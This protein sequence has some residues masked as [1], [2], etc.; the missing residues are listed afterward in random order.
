M[1][2]EHRDR[3]AA[4][5]PALALKELSKSFGATRAV[6][7]LSLSVDHGEVVALLG[8]NGAGKT[9]TIEMCEGFLTPTT[10]SIEVLG[11]NPTTHPEHVRR[12]IG[13]MLQGGGTYP[14]IKVG[15]LLRL[16]ASYS[17]RPL[18]VDWL[19]HTLG[20]EGIVKTNYRRL[21][22]GQ[23]QR[24][25]LACALIGRPELVFLDEPTAGMDAQSRLQVWEIIRSLKADGV[26][27]ILT[28]HIMDEAE[29]LADRVVII[30][31]G[32]VVAEGTPEELSSLSAETAD[33]SFE[34]SVGIDT[35]AF[36]AA[37]GANV[38][39]T[40]PRS[41]RVQAAATPALIETL[42][43]TARAQDVLLRSI[44]TNHRT[45]EDVF[46]DLTG[47]EMRS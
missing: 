35:A 38:V 1:N 24:V 27:V 13:I 22:G 32:S 45:L 2:T 31:H 7:A 25:S 36:S 26:T 28:T 5:G 23:Q 11:I 33:I 41:Y 19:L 21:S 10:G 15:E 47:R 46:L 34:T 4:P 17:A 42:A 37:V 14:G 20:L 8:P 39:E 29:A 12:R 18:D 9:T 44:S 3:T 6:A 40:H 43:A 16:V 30:D